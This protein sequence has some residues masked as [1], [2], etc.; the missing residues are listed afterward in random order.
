MKTSV[1]LLSSVFMAL[2][3]CAADRNKN[4][5]VRSAFSLQFEKFERR[6]G[7]INDELKK[8]SVTALAVAKSRVEKLKIALPSLELAM[9]LEC[10]IAQ[11]ERKNVRRLVQ[12]QLELDVAQGKRTQK[13]ANSLIDTFDCMDL[14]QFCKSLVQLKFHYS[15]R[16]DRYLVNNYC[17]FA[18]K[19][20]VRPLGLLLLAD[21]INKHFDEQAKKEDQGI[22]L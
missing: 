18:K 13:E 3:L 8:Y 4:T 2:S 19:A 9:G 15:K 7:R 12:W 17:Y 11:P 1:V 5:P 10:L 22:I 6:A 16:S 20:N 14:F 21:A